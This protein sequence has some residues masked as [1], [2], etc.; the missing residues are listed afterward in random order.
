MIAVV[1][2]QNIW[3]LILLEPLKLRPIITDHIKKCMDENGEK[4]I[5][6]GLDYVDNNQCPF[7]DQSLENN[8]LF[9]AY[10]SY[11][12][13]S[14]QTLKSKITSEKQRV[15]NLISEDSL[16][17]LLAVISSNNELIDLNWN[18]LGSVV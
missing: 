12:D 18:G 13:E 2:R 6:T 4:W 3:V 7:C 14:Y 16:L 5:E 11:F 8:Q 10:K 17:D 15:Q 9:S 1:C